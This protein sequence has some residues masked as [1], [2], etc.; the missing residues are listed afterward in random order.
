MSDRCE[1]CRAPVIREGDRVQFNSSPYHMD[2]AKKLA[3]MSALK[4]QIE[5]LTKENERLR[6]ERDL[7]REDAER[8][9]A[10]NGEL[11]KQQ[12]DTAKENESLQFIINRSAELLSKGHRDE[13]EQYLTLAA[14]GIK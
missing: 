8:L 5:D 6:S 11:W 4:G 14:K 12:C 2:A 9:R 1:K 13:V 7:E 10:A 3:Q